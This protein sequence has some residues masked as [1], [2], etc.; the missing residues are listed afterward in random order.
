MVILVDMDDTIEHLLVPWLDWLNKEFGRNVR[1]ADVHSWDMREAYPGLT[2]E[3]IFA[4][5]D[6]DAFWDTV[7]P[8]DGAAEVLKKWIDRGHEV[9]IVTSTPVGSVR[10]KMERV[11][12]RYFPFIAWDHVIITAK[13]QL[14]KAEVMV[15]DGYHNL[16]GGDYRK[17]LVDA[18]YNREFD[19]KKDGMIRVYDW[20]EIDEAVEKIEEESA[21][22]R[23]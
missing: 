9:Y 8:I 5:L 6:E 10:A 1:K 16:V 2:K 20:N 15:D 7:P 12:F 4:A 19:E 13:K 11:L 21:G 14:L 17:I 23:V 3:E 18:P 22:D